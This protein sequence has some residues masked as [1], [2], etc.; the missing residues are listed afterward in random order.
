[1]PTHVL[2]DLPIASWDPAECPLCADGRPLTE[3]G[4]RF[5]AQSARAG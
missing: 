2:L 3:P 5:I 1:V 4:S